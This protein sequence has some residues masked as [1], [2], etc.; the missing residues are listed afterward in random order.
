MT[1]IRHATLV[2]SLLLVTG[3]TINYPYELTVTVVSLD[4]GRPVS[5]VEITLLSRSGEEATETTD[6]SGACTL[7][8]QLDPYDFV[9]GEKGD[10]YLHGLEKDKPWRVSIK[11]LETEFVVSCP[12]SPEPTKGQTLVAASMVVAVAQPHNEAEP[13]EQGA[14]D[15]P[16]AR[17]E[18]LG[19][20]K[21]TPKYR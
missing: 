11:Y 10:G 6:D 1:H 16:H 18:E 3:C 5:G 21:H 15:E 20:P 19:Q 13:S 17:C 8:A 4:D 12:P 7:N 9:G 2:L 14:S